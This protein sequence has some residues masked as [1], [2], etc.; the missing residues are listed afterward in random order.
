MDEDN[1]RKISHNNYFYNG[2]NLKPYFVHSQDMAKKL[3]KV[4]IYIIRRLKHFATPIVN[5]K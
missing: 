4:N 1:A 3:F 2:M 5:R